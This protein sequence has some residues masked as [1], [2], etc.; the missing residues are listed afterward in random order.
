MSFHPDFSTA[1]TAE[2][3]KT[4]EAV[5]AGRYASLHL[6]ELKRREKTNY[7][8]L[9]SSGSIW[10]LPAVFSNPFENSSHK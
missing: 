1:F 8:L 5:R 10:C 4:C 7:N 6:T 2:N 3:G 9:P